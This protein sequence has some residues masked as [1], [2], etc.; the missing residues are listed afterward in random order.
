[1]STTPATR[2][3]PA[4]TTCTNPHHDHFTTLAADGST[5]DTAVPAVCTYDQLPMHWDMALSQW[6]HDDTDAPRCRIY[7]YPGDGS[8]CVSCPICT[9]PRAHTH[10]GYHGMPIYIDVPGPYAEVAAELH[11][12]ADAL[13]PLAG[14]FPDVYVGLTLSHK[15]S[16][17][18][19]AQ[20]IAL[21]DALAQ[22]ITGRGAHLGQSFS[23]GGGRR[24]GADRERYEPLTLTIWATVSDPD[25]LS[26]LD[27][28]RREN[29]EL[30][31]AA[32]AAAI[33][34]PDAVTA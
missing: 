15:S 4:G 34:T 32:T 25:E 23:S 19:D 9:D 17:G 22:A 24:Y 29:A 16:S 28:L 27:R 2:T 26:E 31:R 6:R 7:L 11:R 3:A 12:I 21:V 13:A 8:P 1:V 5:L 10:T 30:K 18:T 33:L 14:D 20:R